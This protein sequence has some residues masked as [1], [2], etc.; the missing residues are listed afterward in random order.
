MG[1]FTSKKKHESCLGIDLGSSGIK[2]VELK[3]TKFGVR[4]LNYGFTE[5][6][7]QINHNDWDKNPE[8]TARVINK[9]LK[10]INAVSRTAVV[11]LPSFSV[12]SSVININNSNPKELN[13]AINWEAKKIIP[14]PLEEMILDW[15]IIPE[16]Q[17]K[18]PE[19]KKIKKSPRN[20]KVLLTGAPKTLVKKYVDIFKEAKIHLLSLETETFSLIRSLVGNDESK[21]MF[22]EIGSSTTDISIIKN[23]IPLLN[24]SIDVGGLTI[25]KAISDNLNIG[26]ERA[27][28]FKYDLGISSGSNTNS[29]IP[30][31]ITDSISPIV[32]EIKHMLNLFE[33]KNHERVEKIIL[34]GGSALLPNL[35]EYLSKILNINVIIGNPWT[36]I[37]YPTDLE[38]VLIEIGPKL[39]VSVGLAIRGME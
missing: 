1:L 3:R 14:I 24:R 7:S 18:A 11:A 30:K 35:P 31:T 19:N 29:A 10:N 4:L 16:N 36:K 33:N 15:K 34:S 20:I 2:I 17:K 38:Q 12:F 13:T 6:T 8:Y 26:E 25:T 28:Q 21:I 5:N 27:E 23:I 9:M 22:V 39:A 37:S 32:N